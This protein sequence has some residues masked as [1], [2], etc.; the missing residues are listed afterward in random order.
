MSSF[1]FVS[2]FIYIC[3]FWGL[4]AWFL[5]EGDQPCSLGKTKHKTNKDIP[6]PWGF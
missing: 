2:I 4:S 5:R 1:I 3:R 6:D